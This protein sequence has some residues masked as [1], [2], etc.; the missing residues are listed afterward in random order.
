MAAKVS[1]P[2]TADKFPPADAF[3]S[4]DMV[5]IEVDSGDDKATFTPIKGLLTFYSGYFSTLFNS[6]FREAEEGTVK[7]K[8]EDP[9]IFLLVDHWIL[10]R[11]FYHSHGNALLEPYE[12]LSYTTLAKLYVFGYAHKM[13]L[14]QNIVADA[15]AVKLLTTGWLPNPNKGIGYSTRE[16]PARQ[17][18]KAEEP[19]L[20]N[21]IWS[22]EPRLPLPTKDVRAK[23]LRQRCSRHIH[24]LGVKCPPAEEAREMEE[25]WAKLIDG[26]FAYAIKKVLGEYV[27]KAGSCGEHKSDGKM[28]EASGVQRGDEEVAQEAQ[29]GAGVGLE[30]AFERVLDLETESGSKVDVKY[31]A[32][33]SESKIGAKHEA[34]DNNELPA[35][36]VD[37]LD[38]TA[39]KDKIPE[40]SKEAEQS[41]QHMQPDCIVYEAERAI[42][43]AELKELLARIKPRE[44]KM[45]AHNAKVEQEL[46]GLTPEQLHARANEMRTK[47]TRALTTIIV[48]EPTKEGLKDIFKMSREFQS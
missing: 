15:V 43:T 7:L 48:V 45:S 4:E 18:L 3:R 16:R 21:L 27:E 26:A 24:E 29:N 40:T 37:T 44:Q 30:T 17:D 46:K 13:P 11:Q 5:T 9:Y 25:K 23:F 10:T 32:A 12:M 41:E 20:L 34:A 28:A 22:M 31:E 39:G 6:S 1:P 33:D 36:G 2:S 19:R 14:M 8:T 38:P 35:P 47:F 42:K